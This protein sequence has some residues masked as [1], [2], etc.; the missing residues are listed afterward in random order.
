MKALKFTVAALALLLSSTFACSWYTTD[1]YVSVNGHIPDCNNPCTQQD[2]CTF[3]SALKSSMDDYFDNIIHVKAGL[4]DLS[5]KG[6]EYNISKSNSLTIEG[7]ASA[8]VILDGAHTTIPL[9]IRKDASFDDSDVTIHISNLTFKNGSLSGLTIGQDKSDLLIERSRFIDNGA[10]GFHGGAYIYNKKGNVYILYNIFRNNIAD[11]GGGFLL[12]KE[13]GNI[14]ISRNEFTHNS[15]TY[16]YNTTER[17]GG[18]FIVEA[19]TSTVYIMHNIIAYN[20]AQNSGGGFFAGVSSAN[21]K[22]VITNNTIIYNSAYRGGGIYAHIDNNAATA[23]FYNNIIWN[24]HADTQSNNGDAIYLNANDADCNITRNAWGDDT[25]SLYLINASN[26][27]QSL[28]MRQ[29]VKISNL[30]LLPDGRKSARLFPNSPGVGSG[31]RCLDGVGFADYEGVVTPLQC[32]SI[33]LGAVQ[34]LYTPPMSPI[35]YLLLN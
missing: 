9:I 14:E 23:K 11:Q 3:E 8:L 7:E 24:D 27:T 19:L 34:T 26:V 25:N 30:F 35:Y 12:A 22:M 21:A 28:N 20:T 13:S 17:G 33:N 10:S 5:A 1:Y 2:P 4:Y 31:W 6:L 18:A 32:T 15:S 29:H 16:P